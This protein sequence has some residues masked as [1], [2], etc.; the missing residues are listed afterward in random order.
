MKNTFRNAVMLI[1][2]VV[3]ITS[4][5]SGPVYHSEK[6]FQMQTW[7]RFEKVIF[8]FPVNGDQSYDIELNLSHNAEF[9][10][11]QMPVYV[12]LTTPSGEERMREVTFKLKEGSFIGEV[13]GENWKV[14]TSL[15]KGVKI[16]KPGTC[17]VSVEN[18]N[19]KYE[20]LGI[21]NIG[22]VVNKSE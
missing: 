7:N 2:I 19:P 10:Y 16:A 13:S 21:N 18:M 6:D 15:W 3:S 4:C 12:I 1:A 5:S 14:K 8:D 17:S 9:A 20:T 22:I 11:D